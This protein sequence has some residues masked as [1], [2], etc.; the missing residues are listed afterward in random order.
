MEFCIVFHMEQYY[1]SA[2]LS[3]MPA[4]AAP[5]PLLPGAGGAARAGFG[6]AA[7]PSASAAR[8]P[9]P[10]ARQGRA[11]VGSVATSPGA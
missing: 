7:V 11:G 8:P 9:S 2:G 10:A 3:L 6:A 5:A 4:R 1:R